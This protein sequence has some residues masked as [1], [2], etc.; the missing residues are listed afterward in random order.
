MSPLQR[1]KKFDEILGNNLGDNFPVI[2]K[3]DYETRTIHSF[4]SLD[5]DAPSYQN[6]STLRNTVKGQVDDLSNFTR[7]DDWGNHTVIPEEYDY[8]Q[9]DLI[10]PHIPETEE[11]AIVLKEMLEYAEQKGI[12]FNLVIAE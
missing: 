2:D 12:I 10:V 8:K 4:K 9:L 1:G 3:I 11:Q 7:V 5:L 6:P